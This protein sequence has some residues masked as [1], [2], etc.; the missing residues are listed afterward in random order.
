MWCVFIQR[1]QYLVLLT[2]IEASFFRFL[3]NM[4]SCWQNSSIVIVYMLHW[5]ISYSFL[6][7]VHQIPSASLTSLCVFAFSLF[8]VH[9]VTSL[10]VIDVLFCWEGLFQRHSR[11]LI[12]NNS[13]MS[14]VDYLNGGEIIGC[15]VVLN[16]PRCSLSFCF[17]RQLHKW[18]HAFGCIQFSSLSD[19]VDQLNFGCIFR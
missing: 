9:W 2:D 3:M 12:W 5:M 16:F 17:L 6:T 4:I 14:Y 19:F 7:L 11:R 15:V 10:K 13:S 18:M 1:R 8:G